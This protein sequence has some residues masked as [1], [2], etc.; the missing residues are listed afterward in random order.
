MPGRRVTAIMAAYDLTSDYEEIIDDYEAT[1]DELEVYPSWRL[2]GDWTLEALCSSSDG[3][4]WFPDTGGVATLARAICRG[5]PV[6]LEC[7]DYAIEIGDQWGIWGAL[8][9]PERLE[10]K[11]RRELTDRAGLAA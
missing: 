7:L 11:R 6:R 10:E 5:C 2:P 3:D 1:D 4:A 9:Y 8:S